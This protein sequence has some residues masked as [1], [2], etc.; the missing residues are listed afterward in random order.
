[1]VARCVLTDIVAIVAL[2]IISQYMLHRLNIPPAILLIQILAVELLLQALPISTLKHDTTKPSTG[3]KRQI[4]L[5]IIIFG[6]LAGFV[7]Y[8]S[9]LLFF[10]I[11]SLSPEFI[12][13]TSD[14]YHQATSVTLAT[15]ALCQAINLFFIRADDH[16]HVL[17]NY[18]ISNKKLVQ[19]SAVSLFVLLN[20]I[21]NPLL[22][23]FFG[24]ETI[25]VAGLADIVLCGG[26]Y[27]IARRVQRY[28]RKHSRHEVVKMHQKLPNKQRVIH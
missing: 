16:P 14:L 28:T 23:S 2:L 22:Q 1:M 17:T 5:E 21:Y 4:E 25:S 12:D 19:S 27:A 10:G 8:S 6:I 26:L 3:R 15:L 24:T 20:I 13:R 7:A 18:V 11:H 9:Y